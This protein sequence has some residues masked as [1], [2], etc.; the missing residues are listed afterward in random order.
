MSYNLFV[1][2]VHKIEFD[3][4]SGRFNHCSEELNTFLERICEENGLT[5]LFSHDNPFMED[6]SHFEMSR[7]DIKSLV[8]ILAEKLDVKAFQTGNGDMYTYS[9][10]MKFM[11]RALEIADPEDEFVHFYWM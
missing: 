9:D 10:V 8:A 5:S 1:A 6:S 3:W 7:E 2:K 4:N 11:V